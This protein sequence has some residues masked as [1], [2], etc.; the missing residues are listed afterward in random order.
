MKTR[1]G[2]GSLKHTSVAGQVTTFAGDTRTGRYSIN[3]DYANGDQGNVT[4][5]KIPHINNKQ[6]SCFPH[7]LL[8]FGDDH[9][10]N[11]SRRFSA[12]VR[13]LSWYPG[14]V[15]LSLPQPKSV[16][17]AGLVL[18]ARDAGDIQHD[19]VDWGGKSPPYIYDT[20]PPLVSSAFLRPGNP[21]RADDA[22]VLPH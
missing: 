3:G 1:S 11:V 22:E 12:G 21:Y 10:R 5:I 16:E 8:Q 14:R 19:H 9:A 4:G 7:V 6:N 13:L 15:R 20:C 2:D 18:T 17:N